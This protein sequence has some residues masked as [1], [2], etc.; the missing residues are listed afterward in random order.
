MIKQ[1]QKLRDKLVLFGW[2][3]L[4]ISITG[5]LKGSS[6]LMAFLSI[7]Y[8]I[9]EAPQIKFLNQFKNAYTY[10]FFLPFLLAITGMINTEN[11]VAGWHY[12]EVSLS[13]I[14]F[15]FLASDFSRIKIKSKW[16]TLFLAF[17]AGVLFSFLLCLVRAFIRLPEMQSPY[18]FFYS[19]FSGFI[20]AP[21]H[22]SNYVLF[23]IVPVVIE[24][25]QRKQ[26][27]LPIKSI[28]LLIL[29]LSLLIIFLILLSSKAT[30]LRLG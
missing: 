9:D 13:F 14:I 18:I 25:V 12:V 5:F 26:E 27:S 17:I 20:M 29:M 11:Q 6:M 4:A 21:N 19:E 28:G 15:P 7:L 3:V 22:L 30:L 1:P 10:V 23:A 16:Q 8:F 24:L 2:I